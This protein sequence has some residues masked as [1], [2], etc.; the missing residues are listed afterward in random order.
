MLR[1]LP[2]GQALDQA[3]NEANYAAYKAQAVQEL[4]ALAEKRCPQ[5]RGK[6]KVLDAATERTMQQW[7][8]GSRGSLYG[9]QHRL[10]DMPLL[11]V[12]RLPGLFLAGQN[13]LLPGVLGGIISAAL[14]VGFSQGHDTVLK[15][16]RACVN[17]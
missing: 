17:V 15:E 2:Q 6:W 11:S 13:I 8:V 12:T 14:A 10:Q 16:F 1:F 9:M 4:I 3:L 7:V 5:L